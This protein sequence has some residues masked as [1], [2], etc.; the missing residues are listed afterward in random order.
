MASPA[1]V[2]KDLKALC[3]KPTMMTAPPIPVKMEATAL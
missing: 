3:V 2:R 1:H